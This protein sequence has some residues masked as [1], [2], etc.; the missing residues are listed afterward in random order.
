MFSFMIA[1]ATLIP[2][3]EPVAAYRANLARIETEVDFEVRDG[4][5]LTS[6]LA[7]R[8]AW[9]TGD[10]VL[11]RTLNPTIAGNWASDGYN[12][13]IVN[14]LLKPKSPI[15]GESPWDVREF[16]MLV[17]P[18]LVA[19]RRFQFSSLSV[20]LPSERRE[21]YVRVGESPFRW[22]TMRYPEIL[23]ELFPNK[24][25]VSI[26]GEVEGYRAK[27]FEWTKTVLVK[28]QEWR[29]TLQLCLD[30]SIG[31]LPRFGRLAVELPDASASI[32]EFYMRSTHRCIKGGFVPAEWLSVQFK[33]KD[34]RKKFPNLD[35]STNVL[36]ESGNARM[37][38]FKAIAIRDGFSPLDLGT[39]GGIEITTLDTPSGTV[40]LSP[41]PKNIDQPF[42]EKEVG[43]KIKDPPKLP[44]NWSIG[45]G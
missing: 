32:V 18:T 40:K 24:A 36:P 21:L 41:K 1:S 14:R 44:R 39:F 10:P 17:A 30:P 27:G 45:S 20:Y 6:Q 37:K 38:Q 25:S 2:P 8:R 15:K 4:I 33:V 34:F 28:S 3:A 22:W 29:Y 23:E 7:G 26:P 43:Q 12:E 13:R 9:Q 16:E 19:S 31:S 42:L 35:V 5:G 11:D